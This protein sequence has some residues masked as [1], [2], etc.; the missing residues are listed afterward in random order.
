MKQ[1]VVPTDQDIAR[2]K[3]ILILVTAAL[4]IAAMVVILWAGPI[5]ILIDMGVAFFVF[6]PVLAISVTELELVTAAE[7][8]SMYKAVEN[9]P[10]AKDELCRILQVRQRVTKAEYSR[11]ACMITD[12]HID[13]AESQWVQTYATACQDHGMLQHTEQD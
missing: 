11:I 4:F 6:L 13:A 8:T 2:K 3:R 10:A 5:G 9:I 7:M 1:R 12:G